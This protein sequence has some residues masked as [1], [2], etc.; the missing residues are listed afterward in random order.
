MNID[1]LQR[2]LVVA[3]CLNFT[4][5][6]ERLYIGQSTISRQIAALEQELGVILLIRGPRSV[7]LTE[8]GRVLQR[9]GTKLMTHINEVKD[10]VVD[11]G[12]GTSGKLRITTVPA[13][14]PILNDL[15]LRAMEIYPDIKLSLNYSK[16]VN[17]CQDLELQESK[18]YVLCRKDHRIARQHPDGLYMDDLRDT[19]ICFGRSSLLMVRHPQ[20]YSGDPPTVERRDN[21]SMEGDL[22]MLQHSDSIMV[23]PGCSAINSKHNLALIPLLDE[24]LLHHV[25]LYYRT[26]SVTSTV[27]H[28]LDSSFMLIFTTHLRLVAGLSPSISAGRWASQG[29]KMPKQPAVATKKLSCATDSSRAMSFSG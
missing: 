16:Y 19:D 18:F 8:A 21:D 7:E 26:D 1:Q 10:K 3:D 14:F 22:V 5:A 27:Q 24:D 17:V 28:F 23:L 12:R 6:A 2:F 11:A 15:C 13:Y 20:P 4:T 29:K 25:T 9:E